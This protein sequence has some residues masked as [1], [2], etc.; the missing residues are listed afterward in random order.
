MTTNDTSGKADRSPNIYDV[1][2]QAGVSIVTVSRAFNN[3]PHVS[4]RMRDRVL[5]AAR[6][7]GYKPR[8][9]SKRRMLA[10]IVGHLDQVSAG[11]YKTRLITQI[12]QAA[13]K[14]DFLVEFIPFD[15]LDLATQ[16]HVDGIIEVGLTGAEVL[17]LTTLPKVP[18]LLTNNQ[19]PRKSWAAVCSDHFGEGQ[20]AAAY[21]LERGHR[22]LALVLDERKGWGPEQRQ[23]GVINALEKAGLPAESVVFYS[24]DEHP[25][26]QMAKAML[27]ARCTAALLF[28]DNA[29]LAV[30]DALS[31]ELGK[32]IPEEISI[33]GIESKSV[34]GFLT[35]R[36]TTI[37][38]PLARMAAACVDFVDGK[39]RKKQVRPPAPFPSRLVVRQSVQTLA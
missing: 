25:P 8:V 4:Q 22:R 7:V 28:S 23:A 29:G 33:I 14:K 1:V 21:L 36:W 35:P 9:V 18:V 16:H 20:M 39:I 19:S 10:V 24:A 26:L 31:N 37:E 6:E 15:T 27:E 30:A 13:A 2:R 32:R 17:Q 11:D 12:I 3:Y 5:Q 34:S 38:Q